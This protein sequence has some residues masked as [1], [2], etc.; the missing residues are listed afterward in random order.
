MSKTIVIAEIGENHIG[1]MEIAKQLIREA[2]DAGADYVKF[3]SYDEACFKKDDPE[4]EWFKK[5]SLSDDDHVMLKAY[6]AEHGIA[7]MSSPFSVERARFLREGL[8]E[9]TVKIASGVMLNTSILEY[10]NTNFSKVFLSTGM[11]TISEVRT[12]LGLLTDVPKVYVMHC[13]TQ[14]PCADQDANLFAIQGLHDSLPGMSI[15]YSDHTIGSLAVIGAVAL[16]ATVI[17]KHFTF[18]KNAHEGT[19]HLLSVDKDELKQMI[20]DVRRVETM[21]GIHAKTP[22]KSESEIIEFVRNRFI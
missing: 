8:G 17:E 21:R 11:A 5:V 6:S 22:T 18:D 12:A 20:D 9:D 1:D 4:Y 14:Y 2:A 7:F 3:Q 10:V 13:V 15:G 16:G 19:D